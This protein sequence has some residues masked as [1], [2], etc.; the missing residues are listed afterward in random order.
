MTQGVLRTQPPL[1]ITVGAQDL[2]LHLA[3][4]G[5]NVDSEACLG[6]LR[7]R[8]TCPSATKDVF[9]E[10]TP[11]RRCSERGCASED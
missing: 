8:R 11:A 5:T 4:V 10:A 2:L 7:T 3:R 1:S 9:L 6:F